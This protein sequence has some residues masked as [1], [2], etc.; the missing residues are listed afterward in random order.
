M[1][2]IGKCLPIWLDLFS[3]RWQKS[4]GSRG[5]SSEQKLVLKYSEVY[6]DLTLEGLD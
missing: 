5:G 6:V 4:R 3:S 1:A 2:L